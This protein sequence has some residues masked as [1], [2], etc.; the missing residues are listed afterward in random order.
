MFKTCSV[1]AAWVVSGGVEVSRRWAGAGGA[2]KQCE[3]KWGLVEDCGPEVEVEVGRA[4]ER[5]SEVGVDALRI[6]GAPVIP[7][8]WMAQCD[9]EVTDVRG[10][11][12]WVGGHVLAERTQGSFSSSSGN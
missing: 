6:K 8:R 3:L 9:C 1:R 12:R 7:T 5:P 11:F 10:I 4:A 2:L